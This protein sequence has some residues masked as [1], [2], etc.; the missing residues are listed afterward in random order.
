M[1]PKWIV[2]ILRYFDCWGFCTEF[3]TTQRRSDE[4][5]L[6]IL[7]LHIVMDFFAAWSIVAFLKRPTD[8][9]LGHVNDV[10]KLGGILF[11][12]F[13]S[14][15]ESYFKRKR[16]RRFWHVFQKIEQ[17]Y[18][19]RQSFRLQSYLKKFAFFIFG[20]I[21]ST[22]YLM[23]YSYHN[24]SLFIN[25]PHFWFTYEIVTRQ[26]RNRVLYYLFYLE[27]VENEL[28]TIEGLARDAAQS[29]HCSMYKIDKRENSGNQS[30]LKRIFEYYQLACEL[31]E[32]LN[33]V[34]GWSNAATISF[35]FGLILTELNW[36][37]WIWYNRFD[38][39]NMIDYIFWI[40]RLMFITFCVFFVVLGCKKR[41]K[42]V[43]YYM[44]S[45]KFHWNDTKTASQVESIFFDSF[46][47]PIT[48][49]AK[50]LF[51]ISQETMLQ[52]IN[53]ITIYMTVFIQFS[54]MYRLCYAMVECLRIRGPKSKENS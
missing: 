48:F 51:E 19:S 12:C 3:Q 2:F 26:Y 23:F 53:R 13:L 5:Y 28:K 31:S 42:K 43:L 47:Q 44:G 34:F 21:T 46:H 1:E 49:H 8:D 35:L 16:Q 7:V 32:E 38:I 37:Y 20:S 54:P 27:L 29:S 50:G 4:C 25:Y 10:I 17:S 24:G 40:L 18:R 11:V 39:V 41:K 52:L 33:S 15:T 22:L 36:V 30:D 45:I 6:V 14:V 9:E